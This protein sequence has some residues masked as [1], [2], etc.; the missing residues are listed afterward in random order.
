M[1]TTRLFTSAMPVGENTI[2]YFTPE[3]ILAIVSPFFPNLFE[4]Y[5][6]FTVIWRKC[7]SKTPLSYHPNKWN[8]QKNKELN[9]KICLIIKNKFLGISL[10]VDRSK[11]K[12][13][14][15]ASSNN[16][17]NTNMEE[18]QEK[19]PPADDFGAFSI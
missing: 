10:R 18:L 7:S 19:S 17:N 1:E 14:I 12:Q 9:S 2:S 11:N 3:L 8:T 16:E 15:K 13:H 4:C 6:A 5:Q